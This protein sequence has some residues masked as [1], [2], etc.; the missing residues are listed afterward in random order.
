MVHHHDAS[1]VTDHNA[2]EAYDEPPCK[3]FWHTNLQRIPFGVAMASPSMGAIKRFHTCVDVAHGVFP[4]QWLDAGAVIGTNAPAQP[5]LSS[6]SSGRKTG[7]YGLQGHE[8]DTPMEAARSMY[9]VFFLPGRAIRRHGP[10][11]SGRSTVWHRHMPM[12][13]AV[14]RY[15]QGSASNPRK[16]A[17]TSER[18]ALT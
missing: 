7:P 4:V 17:Y 6:I 9:D 1:R 2:S 11:R 13:H 12:D 15:I 5:L 10:S 3:C 18:L 16:R 8:G 14:G